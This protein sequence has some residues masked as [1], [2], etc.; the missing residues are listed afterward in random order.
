MGISCL[1]SADG[2]ASNAGLEGK[3]RQTDLGDLCALKSAP[4]VSCCSRGVLRPK[5]QSSPSFKPPSC[6][7]TWQSPSDSKSIFSYAARVQQRARPE[8]IPPDRPRPTRG[9]EPT[10]LPECR[11]SSKNNEK[12]MI[13]TLIIPLLTLA[14]RNQQQR[15]TVFRST[16][17]AEIL[18]RRGRD[19]IWRKIQ[20]LQGEL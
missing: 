6:M 15:I 9:R 19:T 7:G 10:R 12:S 1:V 4:T 8:A 16:S 18:V 3:S 13:N 11:R 14:S 2:G 5:K 17:S 20:V